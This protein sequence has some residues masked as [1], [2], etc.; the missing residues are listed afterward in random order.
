MTVSTL[1]CTITSIIVPSKDGNK[2][3]I[4]LAYGDITGYVNDAYYIGCVVGRYAG[5]ISDA[6]FT[7]DGNLYPLSPNEL[8]TGNHLHGGFEGFNRKNFQLVSSSHDDSTASLIFYYNSRHLEEGYPGNL[9]IWVTYTLTR[10]NKIIIEYKAITDRKTHVNLTNHTYFNF[11]GRH[12]TAT[13]HLLL[14][15]ADAYVETGEH[16]IPTG[17]L[18]DVQGTPFDF[19]KKR[20][21]D[22]SFSLLPTGYNECFVLNKNN[23]TSAVLSENV[24]GIEMT[25]QTSL[26][27]LLL[28]TGDFLGN[29]F[30]KN[31]GI[32]LETQFFPDTPHHTK[33]PSTL[34]NPGEEYVENTVWTFSHE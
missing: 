11:T 24:S 17:I 5:R 28:Y 34:L 14:I 13:D 8:S 27:G 23:I 26:P 10:Q 21:I 18:K 12:E 4:V 31:Q 3:N 2:R 33:F 19:R 7:I 30:C 15:N 20:R 9:E 32:C 29:N 6:S 1:G 22:E 16:Y 25:V